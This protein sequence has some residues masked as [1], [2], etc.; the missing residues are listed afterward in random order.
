MEGARSV[1][2]YRR[3]ADA[4]KSTAQY[5]ATFLDADAYRTSG[6]IQLPE[7]LPLSIPCII[8]ILAGDNLTYDFVTYS[9]TLHI[10]S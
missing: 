5:F 9:L 3:F 1:A 8:K 2:Q 4:S 10:L 6:R 7:L